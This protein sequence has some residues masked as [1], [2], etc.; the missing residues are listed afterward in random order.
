MSILLTGA[1]PAEVPELAR[2]HYRSWLETYPEPAAGIDLAWLRANRAELLEAAGRRRWLGLVE[3]AGRDPQDWFLRVAR[4]AA[5]GEILGFLCGVVGVGGQPVS[6]GPMYLLRAA[7]G[8]GVGDRLMGEFLDWAAGRPIALWA[9]EYNARAIRFY[10]R[11]GFELTEERELWRE[12]L[13]N[14]RMVRP[15]D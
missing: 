7:Q 14:V 13:P 12:R 3:S 8:Q 1:E 10:Q 4:S 15:G 6:L 11:Y 2:V 9:T 5:D